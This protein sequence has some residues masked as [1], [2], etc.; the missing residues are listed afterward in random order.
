MK[1]YMV[2]TEEFQSALHD[3]MNTDVHKKIEQLFTTLEDISHM[4]RELK[5]FEVDIG[6]LFRDL[7]NI[8][9][10]Q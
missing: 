2:S 10:I 3:Q 4:E 9:A 8:E 6:V 1:E 5:E 7:M